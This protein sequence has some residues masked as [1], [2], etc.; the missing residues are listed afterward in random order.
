MTIE[1]ND[2][3]SYLILPLQPNK[4]NDIYCYYRYN[5]KK[6][7]LDYTMTCLEENKDK[8]LYSK[9]VESY[10]TEDVKEKCNRQLQF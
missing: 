2:I 5:Y 8:P 3:V 7:I 6:F 9:L 1:N 10:H 4:I